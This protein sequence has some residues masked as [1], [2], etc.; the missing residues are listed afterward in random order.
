MVTVDSRT[1]K[2]KKEVFGPE[3]LLSHEAGQLLGVGPARVRQLDRDGLLV[4]IRTPSGWRLFR[5]DDVEALVL[6]RKAK[7]ATLAA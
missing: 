5:R 1:M 4:S 7:R 2:V 6:K 3:F